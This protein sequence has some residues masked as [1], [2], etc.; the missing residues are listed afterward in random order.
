MVLGGG[1]L[2]VRAV[3]GL[4][5]YA[6]FVRWFYHRWGPT[7]GRV[8]A[9]ILNYL[10]QNELTEWAINGVIDYLQGANSKPEVERRLKTTIRQISNASYVPRNTWNWGPT[11]HYASFLDYKLEPLRQ[12]TPIS[13]S[14]QQTP[15]TIQ[16]IKALRYVLGTKT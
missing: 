11:K 15:L 9:N 12:Q 5:P 7:I 10:D 3:Q 1:Q 13:R 4:G 16:H 2:I 14:R 8:A 6:R